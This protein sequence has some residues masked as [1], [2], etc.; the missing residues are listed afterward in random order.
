MILAY[1]LTEQ[2]RVT[3][4]KFSHVWSNNLNMDSK[5]TQWNKDSVI[6]KWYWENRISTCKRMKL[7]TYLTPYTKINSK[8]IKELNIK[9]RT[10]T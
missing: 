5:N 4:N 2:N 9:P 3:R 1:R 10:V 8:W 7:D 6:N